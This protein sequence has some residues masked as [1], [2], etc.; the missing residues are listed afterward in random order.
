ME[1]V[2]VDVSSQAAG[3][4]EF[5]V[6]ATVRVSPLTLHAVARV[7]NQNKFEAL[8]EDIADVVGQ[9]SCAQTSF[10]FPEQKA[11]RVTTG[12]VQLDSVKQCQH[13][14]THISQVKL[15]SFVILSTDRQHVHAPEDCVQLEESGCHRPPP[16]LRAPNQKCSST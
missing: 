13:L 2:S 4:H 14:Q 8:S 5:E 11:A 12:Q 16:L 7:T 10:D 3:V 9:L 15:L 6:G 1:H